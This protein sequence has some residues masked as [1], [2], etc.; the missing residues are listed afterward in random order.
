MIVYLGIDDTD[1]LE[2]RG[3][4]FRARR[5]GASLAAEGL[6][7]MKAV[8]R[9]QLLIDQ[10]ISYTSQ[11]SAACLVLE[12]A[13]IDLS[14]LIEYA[15]EQIRARSAPGSDAGVAIAAQQELGDEVIAFGQAT[16][17]AL[18]SR[19][20]AHE[21]A[22]HNGVRA[23]GLTGSG[24][25]VIGALAAVGLHH[26]GNDGRFIWLPE[27]RQL[28]GTYRADELIRRLEVEPRAA[29][30]EQVPLQAQIT[31]G[32]WVRPVLRQ[33]RAILLAEPEN[34]DGKWRLIDRSN[35]KALSN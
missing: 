15:G 3:T 22:T 11:N 10:R 14:S 30:G 33:G 18:Q 12:V 6:A 2:S 29:N 32:D 21:L 25:G 4:G 8:T 27:L 28:A 31:L 24:A 23:A 13:S 16:K 5:L 19:D 35:V 7:E 1:D 34:E 26:S 20:A 17:I 9:H